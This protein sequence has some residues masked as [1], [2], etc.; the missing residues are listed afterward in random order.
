LDRETKQGDNGGVLKDIL[1][2]IDVLIHKSSYAEA[3]LYGRRA[4]KGY[5]KMGLEGVPGVESSLK[6]LIRICHVNAN[7]D[8]ADAYAEILSDFLRLNPS[9]SNST[10]A[11]ESNA[12]RP[13]SPSPVQSSRDGRP[14]ERKQKKMDRMARSY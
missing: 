3:H 11:A 13:E 2:L 9:N 1:T 5:R 4:L 8:E 12:Q 10:G 14:E 7:H 6:A